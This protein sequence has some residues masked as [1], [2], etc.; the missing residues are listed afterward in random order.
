MDWPPWLA[1]RFLGGSARGTKGAPCPPATMAAPPALRRMPR[2]FELVFVVAR[3][4]VHMH[5]EQ[6]PTG[7]AAG[8][9]SVHSH[10]SQPPLLQWCPRRP[11]GAAPASQLSPVLPL[12]LRLWICSIYASHFEKRATACEKPTGGPGGR[13]AQGKGGQRVQ[14]PRQPGWRRA[15]GWRIVA[16]KRA[17]RPSNALNWDNTPPRGPVDY[18][19]SRQGAPRRTRAGPLRAPPVACTL[20]LAWRLSSTV[21]RSWEPGMPWRAKS[22]S[23][24]EPGAAAAAAA[25]PCPPCRP[26]QSLL[27]SPRLLQWKWTPL[28]ARTPWRACTSWPTS[29]CQGGPSGDPCRA[30]R[31]SGTRQGE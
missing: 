30:T 14:R 17:R 24:T 4:N 21:L 11:A 31:V 13:A 16:L 10:A 28:Q 26:R 23:A 22:E 8:V 29:R 1:D 3:R 7:G 6:K 27:P 18:K 5:W 9:Q 19:A 12:A 25:P 20:R 15:L 2:P